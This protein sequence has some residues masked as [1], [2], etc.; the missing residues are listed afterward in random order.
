MRNLARS[1]FAPCVLAL[2]L[3]AGAGERAPQLPARTVACGDTIT[4]SVRIANS[5]IDCPADGLIVG[6]PGI[7]I[8]LGGHRVDGAG[9]GNGITARKRKPYFHARS[10][11]WSYGTV[12]GKRPATSLSAARLLTT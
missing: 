11:S 12:I 7:V 8:D 9:T 2:A 5:L 10:N 6:A 1:L 3:P 4:E